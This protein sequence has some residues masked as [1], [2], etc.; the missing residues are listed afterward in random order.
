MPSFTEIAEDR[1]LFQPAMM[2]IVVNRVEQGELDK[3]RATL[4]I[5]NAPTWREFKERIYSLHQLMFAAAKNKFLIQ[6]MDDI[7]ADRR[8]VVFD[9]KNTDN[10]APLPVRL[11]AGTALFSFSQFGP[12]PTQRTSP[13]NTATIRIT[14]QT[15]RSRETNWR[16]RR[17]AANS[18]PPPNR[19]IYRETP[20]TASTAN[21][22]H[23][24]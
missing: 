19:E 5:L 6:I 23:V 1:L 17:S 9:S 18:S 24:S 12:Q 20:E 16:W 22:P 2:Q 14:G 4:E 8:A 3:M 21:P 13:R 10:P 11:A 7:I 15:G